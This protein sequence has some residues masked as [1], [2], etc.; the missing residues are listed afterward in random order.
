MANDIVIVLVKVRTTEREGEKLISTFKKINH[1]RLRETDPFLVNVTHRSCA[2]LF[3]LFTNRPKTRFLK[4]KS[5]LSLESVPIQV[6]LD[7]DDDGEPTE[8]R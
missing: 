3:I 4:S 7:V 6:L 8:L 1:Q 5:L 2:D